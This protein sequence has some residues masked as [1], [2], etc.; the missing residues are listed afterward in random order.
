MPEKYTPLSKLK[1]GGVQSVYNKQ[2]KHLDEL[3]MKNRKKQEVLIEL[4][5]KAR[6]KEFAQEKITEQVLNKMAVQRIKRGKAL[7]KEKP[8]M[9]PF[10]EA[11]HEKLQ[12]A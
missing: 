3:A 1:D 9:T 12:S 6:K 5:A 7:K 2:R 4:K 10:Q 8:G 11:I